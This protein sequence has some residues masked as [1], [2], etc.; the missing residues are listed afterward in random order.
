M[1]VIKSQLIRLKLSN[2]YDQS[3][4]SYKDQ[5]LNQI[6]IETLQVHGDLNLNLNLPACLFYQIQFILIFEHQV[7]YLIYQL[8]KLE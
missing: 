4:A 1:K 7:C 2:T 6:L 5:A 3:L 8:R